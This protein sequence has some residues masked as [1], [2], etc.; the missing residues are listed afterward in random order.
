MLLA[1][2]RREVLESFYEEFGCDK[3][4][5]VFDPVSKVT[6]VPQGAGDQVHVLEI[7]GNR[8]GKPVGGKDDCG[9]STS[10]SNTID[11]MQAVLSHLH[12]VQRQIDRSRKEILSQMY[13]H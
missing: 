13:K 3:A 5:L 8:S 4:N 1:W 11:D 2:L 6:I 10:I 9:K 7:R 12:Q